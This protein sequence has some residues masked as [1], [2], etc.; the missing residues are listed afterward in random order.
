MKIESE[1]TKAKMTDALITIFEKARTDVKEID[2]NKIEIAEKILESGNS[3]LI[4]ANADLLY[5]AFMK[6]L[7]TENKNDINNYPLVSDVK[8]NYLI[9]ANCQVANSLYNLH[10]EN[11]TTLKIQN[12]AIAD[13]KL[14]YHDLLKQ[15]RDPKE[16][17]IN[18]IDC[19][20]MDAI[21]SLYASCENVTH[22]SIN[23]ICK[24]LMNRKG[25]LRKSDLKEKEVTWSVVKL[26]HTY[27]SYKPTR[28]EYESYKDAFDE[29]PE[30]LE[31]NIPLLILNDA[32]MRTHNHEIVKGYHI[33]KTPLIFALG[34][35]YNQNISAKKFLEL[36]PKCTSISE[37]AL[38]FYLY[39]RV[40]IMKN[41]SRDIKLETLNNIIPT[42]TPRKIREKTKE[43]LQEL[44][45]NGLISDFKENK[46]KQ[47][48][49]IISYTFYPIGYT[50]Y[51]NKN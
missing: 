10:N 32:K 5:Y 34:K 14:T 28:Q 27:L 24:I 36:N 40:E 44:K 11:T 49:K 30:Y 45:Q 48:G 25:K 13:V 21:I 37:R 47:S 7:I 15:G 23:Q 3:E 9:D 8:D 6:P 33:M 50:D 12:K 20:V 22:I 17:E 26:T 16:Y 41:C 19:Y 2:L 4:N 43:Y 51:T 39:K 46:V 42:L 1:H 31:E 38:L 18:A 29:I 35:V